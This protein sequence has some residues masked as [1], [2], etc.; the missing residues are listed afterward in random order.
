MSEITLLIGT[1][2]SGKSTL[3]QKMAK[4]GA[5]IINDDAIVTSLHGD[6]QLYDPKLKPLYKG[7]ENQILSY[8]V[9]LNKDIVV[10]RGLNLTVQSRARWIDLAC[11]FD[12]EISAILFPFSS[13]NVHAR[14]RMRHDDRGNDR[15]TWKK[16]A[17]HHQN[18]YEEPSLKEGFKKIIK[19]QFNNLTGEVECLE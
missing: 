2:G 17:E 11:S 12:C 13:P 10:D 16:I 1:I 19:T 18:V 4:N 7:I 15:K 5:L 6:Y 14:R 8:G 3:S 9:L